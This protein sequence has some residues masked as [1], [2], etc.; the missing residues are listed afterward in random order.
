MHATVMTIVRRTPH[1]ARRTLYVA[2]C[3]PHAARRT[4]Y[5]VRRTPPVLELLASDSLGAMS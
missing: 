3:T 4:L 1:A 5:A 2:R